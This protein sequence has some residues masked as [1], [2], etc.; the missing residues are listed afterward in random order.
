MSL[1]FLAS[2]CPDSR[3]QSRPHQMPHSAATALIRRPTQAGQTANVQQ[4]MQDSLCLSSRLERGGGR[5]AARRG[6]CSL[7]MIAM[8]IARVYS[9]LTSISATLAMLAL[10][11]RAAAA[12][13]LLL[14][15]KQSLALPLP[16]E[17]ET[18]RT[19]LDDSA[20]AS[21]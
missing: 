7:T 21:A 1:L 12:T 11:P 20:A 8:P 16:Q 4:Q 19:Y 13:R 9:P 2:S 15:R 3:C 6:G 5:A 10:Q 14:H 18:T 17:R